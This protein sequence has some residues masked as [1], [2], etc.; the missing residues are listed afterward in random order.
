MLFFLLT[1]SF[2]DRIRSSYL[3]SKISYIECFKFAKNIE[4]GIHNNIPISELKK[5]S[6]EFCN[7]I[8]HKNQK[9][10]CKSLATDEQFNKIYDLLKNQN[11]DPE[12][13]CSKMGYSR[14]FGGGRV[15]SEELCTN[16]IDKLKEDVQN[17]L[18]S[19]ENLNETSRTNQKKTRRSN[20]KKF[21]KNNSIS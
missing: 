8:S 17:K 12:S 14:G 5:N 7:R 3:K 20:A 1:L 19:E 15:I 18:N 21:P 9:D 2:A 13:V 10:F 11:L 4:E 6:N 16:I